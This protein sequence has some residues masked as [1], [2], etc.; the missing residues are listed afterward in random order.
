[1]KVLEPATHVVEA[2][3][4][5]AVNLVVQIR[6]NVRDSHTVTALRDTLLSDLVSRETRLRNT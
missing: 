6:S 3:G 2:I 1:M 4:I 5:K